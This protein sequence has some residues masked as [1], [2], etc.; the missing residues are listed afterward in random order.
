MID[1]TSSAINSET[2]VPISVPV[3][4]SNRQ[5]TDGY[6]TDSLSI[7]KAQQ[8]LESLSNLPAA[9]PDAVK[10]GLMLLADP[11]Y[12]SS[13]IVAQIAGKLL[14]SPDLAESLS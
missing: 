7:S 11:N 4:K 1:P 12:P 9:R 10:Q 5:R 3:A 8:L 6:T 2:I 13:L 14:N